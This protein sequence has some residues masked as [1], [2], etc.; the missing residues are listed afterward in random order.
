MNST[1]PSVTWPSAAITFQRA[2]YSPG[3]SAGSG[4]TLFSMEFLFRGALEHG[5]MLVNRNGQM[6]AKIKITSVQKDRSIA[7]V[8]PG[9]KLGEVL[10]GDQVIP[11]HPAQS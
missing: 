9:W 2:W 5:E 8:M 4:K 7:N 3:P 1:V 11:A 10:E 6:V